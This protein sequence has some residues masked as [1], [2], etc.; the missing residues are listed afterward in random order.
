M[1][2]KIFEKTVYIENRCDIYSYISENYKCTKNQFILNNITSD[3]IEIRFRNLGGKGGFGRALKQEGERRSRK[4]P[5]FK[6]SCRTLSGK[7][8]GTI[9]AKKRIQQLK[10]LIK[11][12]EEKV[13]EKNEMRRRSNAEKETKLLEEREKEASKNVQESIQYAISNPTKPKQISSN[14]L[15]DSIDLDGLLDD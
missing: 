6:D 13:K 14:S 11:E 8:I 10:K 1:L 15:A 2:L 7:R 5:H 9:K 12:K 3:F 4:L